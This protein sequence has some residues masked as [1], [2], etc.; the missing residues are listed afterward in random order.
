MNNLLINLFVFLIG[1]WSPAMH[2]VH[3][4]VC[5]MEMDD[6]ENIVSFKLFK[7]DFALVLKNKYQTDVSMEKADD[8]AN[9]TLISNYIN[10]CFQLEV[11]KSRM[12]A[13]KYKSS[14]I[15]EDAVW[16]H[17]QTEKLGNATQLQI[18]NTLMLDLWDNQ[19]NLL[20]LKWKEKEIGYKFDADVTITE[21]DL[22]K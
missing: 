14:E 11:N 21:I 3:V 12:L 22:N 6:I 10:S 9:S 4:S 5:N 7:D 8:K 15:N 19:T 17:F 13:L 16:I 2:P 1:I 20:I 18:T